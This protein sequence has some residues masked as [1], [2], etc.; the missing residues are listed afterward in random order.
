MLEG[1]RDFWILS[2]ENL[3][4]GFAEHM[5][6]GTSYENRGCYFSAEAYRKNIKNLVEFTRRFSSRADY[7]DYFYKGDGMAQGIE[8]LAQKKK[9]PFTG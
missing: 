4:P 9:G 5:I 8:F 2:D 7:Q 1:S 6:L 3:K